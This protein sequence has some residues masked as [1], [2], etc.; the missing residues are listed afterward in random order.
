MFGYVSVNMEEMKIRDYRRYHAF[1]CGICQDLKEYHGQ[2]ARLSL[3]YDMT[4]LA[5]LLTGLY[6]D[7]IKEE[8]Y[9]CAPHPLSKHES[10]RNRMTAY[11]AD[12]NVLI[13]YYNLLDDWKDEKKLGSLFLAGTMKRDVRVL[14]KNYPRQARAIR[15][16]L[17]KLEA[18]ETERSM[19][20]D[21]A[22]GDTGRLFA[23]LFVWQEDM[24]SDTLRKIGFYLGKYIY[25]MDAYED[26]EKDKKNGNYNPWIAI[27]DEDDYEQRAGQILMYQVAACTREFEKLPILEYVEILRNILYSGIWMKYDRMKL[28]PLDKADDH[29]KLPLC[30]RRNGA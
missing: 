2:T 3:T 8:K 9:F 21:R 10:Y 4:F 26:L 30:W 22:S 18:C 25:L 15:L 11:A 17:K 16:Y 13:S 23:E 20:L 5:I 1:Y 14:V 7:K 19:D 27:S 24:W 12:M 6:E 29:R 28:A